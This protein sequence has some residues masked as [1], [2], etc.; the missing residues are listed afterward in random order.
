MGD[1]ARRLRIA[2]LARNTV[3]ALFVLILSLHSASCFPDDKPPTD[4]AKQV[5]TKSSAI[6]C[7]HTE[8]L[9]WRF[10]DKIKF[11]LMRELGRQALLIAARDELGLATRD[12]T[13]GEI[14][15]EAITSAKNDLFVIVRSQYDGRVDFQL[16][17]ASE[18]GEP[19]PANEES[20]HDPNAIVNQ[21]TKLEPLTHSGLCKVL[22]EQGFDGKPAPPNEKNL[23]PD[24]IEGQLLEMN[25]VSQFAAVRAAHAAISEK[26]QSKGWLS[27]L[28]R[29][30]ANLGM[31]TGHHWMSDSDAFA[32]RAL[33]YAERL[34]ASAP[35]DSHAFATRAYARA[36]VGLHAAALDDLKRID[37]LRKQHP[38][39]K[40]LPG[41]L[42]V[43][44]PYCSFEREPLRSIVDRRP[45]LRQLAQRLS[46]EQMRAFGDDRWLFEAAKPSIGI[47][48]EE[49]GV[50][51]ALTRA[52]GSLLSVVRT[53]AYYAPMALQHFLP[54][55]VAALESA[56]QSVRDA[57]NGVLK[58]G[59]KNTK[60]GKADSK[61]EDASRIA[62]TESAGEFAGGTIPIVEALRAATRGGDDKGEPTWSALGE[63]VFEEQFVQA[64]NY[65]QVSLNATESSHDDE[66]K[67][68]AHAIRGHR[69]ARYIEGFA[70]DK[71]GNPENYYNHI[72][73]MR[74]L[75]ARG[76]M[77]PMIAR[78]WPIEQSYNIKRC[79]EA[80]WYACNGD[81]TFNSLLETYSALNYLFWE[82]QG[83]DKR[84][85]WAANFQ[86]LSPHSPQSLRLAIRIVAKPTLEQLTQWESQA[87]EDP[88]AYRQLGD[89]FAELKHYEDAIRAFEQSVKLSPTKES[90]I[91]LANAYRS[92]GQEELWQPTL[93][94]FFK[95]E[96]LGLE[97]ASVHYLIATELA[98]KGKWKEAEPHALAAGETYSDWGLLIASRV[99]EGL[100]HW[101]ESEQLVRAA[102]TSYPSC[103]APNWYFWCRRTGRGDLESAKK[104]IQ[105]YFS[106]SSSKIDVNYPMNSFIFHSCEDDN[107][108]TLAVQQDLVKF[109]TDAN[110]PPA[111]L[112]RSY[113]QSALIT[114]T[115]KDS[116]ASNAAVK[117]TRELCAEFREQLPDLS[118]IYSAT[119]DILDGKP[120]TD[121]IRAEIDKKIEAQQ[122][123]QGRVNCQ[124]FLGRAYAL[125]G[126]E[127]LAEKYWNECV[128]RGPYD[129]Y[130]ATLA[131]K[132]LADRHKTSRP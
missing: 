17:K 107:R 74:I 8:F 96:S 98:D 69:Y 64:A 115:M 87:G 132:F 43:V 25:F 78:I 6:V 49:Y 35:D 29:G 2:C 106:A 113:I 12:E 63:L 70:A 118:A 47:C 119:C 68:M 88:Y 129:R 89:R 11:R 99:E 26:G 56:P 48:P 19:N 52:S 50:Y 108:A 3:I 31:M 112:V 84:K 123:A 34:A 109:A 71:L 120:P 91:G 18:P 116:D 127:K 94:R 128:T 37:E 7:L 111:D 130:P 53:G 66:V 90:F 16:W 59:E 5:S 20:S 40:Q 10:E 86:A 24:S 122:Q 58:T 104:M 28:A 33:L 14:F 23:V 103:S 110:F 41:W 9:P 42:D 85:E 21:T 61:S 82:Q 13:L 100:G 73:D 79:S 36:I 83:E 76:N 32:A 125:A 114:R 97:Q 38:E 75:D 30:Y 60:A 65:L 55:R 4:S 27:V 22:R 57:A 54:A 44:S 124:Y 101:D 62:A 15:P 95:F 81:L 126:N 80:A 45:S 131:G 1:Y 77:Q 93:E 67:S 105:T 102:A 121:E 51:A 72:G 92:A 39:Q 46:F 117:K